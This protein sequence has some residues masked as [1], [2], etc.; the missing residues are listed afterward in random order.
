MKSEKKKKKELRPH[1]CYKQGLHI[2]KSGAE[3]TYRWCTSDLPDHQAVLDVHRGQDLLLC[4][5]FHRIQ[6]DQV[7]LDRLSSLLAHKHLVAHPFHV[8]PAITLMLMPAS[9]KTVI[10]ICTNQFTYWSIK[11][12]CCYQLSCYTTLFCTFI[13]YI[14]KFT[15]QICI[16][17]FPLSDVICWGM[18]VKIL[19]DKAMQHTWN[20]DA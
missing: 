18:S 12:Y 19:N 4:P 17:Y 6:A 20:G 2:C 13:L 3:L 15:F 7:F 9:N 1:I 10:A 11:F 14:L 16:S 8:C 5:S